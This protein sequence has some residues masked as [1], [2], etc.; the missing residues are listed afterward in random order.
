MKNLFLILMTVITF[1][2]LEAKNFYGIIVADIEDPSIGT[3]CQNDAQL[4]AAE[5]KEFAEHNN[6]FLV[7]KSFTG[8][9]FSAKKLIT[10]LNNIKPEK[11]DVIFF[12]YSGHGQYEEGT[13]KV[14]RIDDG[15]LELKS[16]EKLLDE[17]SA[18]LKFIVTDCCS[19]R[20]PIEYDKPPLR[21]SSKG[22][23]IRQK[24]YQRLLNY[25]GLLIVESSQPGQFSYS[26]SSGG[27]FTDFFLR[28]IHANVE[29][30]EITWKK[31]LDETRREVEEFVG[32]H[33]MK[34]QIPVCDDTNL[35]QKLQRENES[36]FDKNR[37]TRRIKN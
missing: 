25:E 22:I 13:G 16:V 26:D 36:G 33:L 21:F 37:T 28:A 32:E 7:T 3:A 9:N 8:K 2:N 30:G 29:F 10:Y 18:D 34:N 17:M 4:M 27:I 5:F 31:I 35:Y 12:Y 15:N 24:N 23:A 19:Q 20:M 1:Q 11:D 14:L 6:S